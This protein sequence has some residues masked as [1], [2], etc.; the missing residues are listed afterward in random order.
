MALQ[1]AEDRTAS[2]QT[3]LVAA[4]L[5]AAAAADHKAG[6]SFCVWCL[7]QLLVLLSVVCLLVRPFVRLEVCLSQHC[8][9]RV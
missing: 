1:V 3:Q 9:I 2:L 6:N 8:C 5:E 4:P 7:T